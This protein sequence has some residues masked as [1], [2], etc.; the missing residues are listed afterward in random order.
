MDLENNNN[1]FLALPENL[2]LSGYNPDWA[3]YIK[4]KYQNSSDCSDEYSNVKIDL[5]NYFIK[6]F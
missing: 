6:Q 2:K 5:L 4:L 1:D 3:K